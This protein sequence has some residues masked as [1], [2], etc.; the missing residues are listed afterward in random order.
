MLHSGIKTKTYV[1]VICLFLNAYFPLVIQYINF[2]CFNFSIKVMLEHQ[3]HQGHQGHQDHQVT[4]QVQMD[5]VNHIDIMDKK[6]RK[7]KWLVCL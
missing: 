3:D 4:L 7:E 6:D 1:Y 2:L 5:T